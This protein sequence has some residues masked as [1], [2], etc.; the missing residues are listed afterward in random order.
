MLERIR[1]CGLFW[2]LSAAVAAGVDADFQKIVAFGDPAPGFVEPGVTFGALPFQA[3][4][5]SGGHVV[6]NALAR[7][8]PGPIDPGA[9]QGV[10]RWF[11]GGMSLV[12]REGSSPGGGGNPVNSMFLSGVDGFGRMAVAGTV[13]NGG[14]IGGLETRNWFGTPGA[15]VF[16]NDPTALRVGSG[17]VHN[18]A[19]NDGGKVAMTLDRVVRVEGNVTGKSII[20]GSVDTGGAN[21]VELVRRT[22]AAGDTGAFFGTLVNQARIWVADDGVVFYTSQLETAGFSNHTSHSLWAQRDRFLDLDLLASSAQAAPGVPGAPGWVGFVDWRVTVDRR[23]VFLGRVIVPATGRLREGLWFTKAGDGSQ[24]VVLEGTTA[25]PGD[26]AGGVIS[27][28]EE[29]DIGRNGDVMFRASLEDGRSGLFLWASGSLETLLLAGD[30]VPLRPGRRIE[31]LERAVMNPRGDLLATMRTEAA[32]GPANRTRSMWLIPSGGGAREILR[33]LDEIEI[34]PGE[35]MGLLGFDLL[36]FDLNPDTYN[37]AGQ[38]LLTVRGRVNGGSTVDALVFGAL[39]LVSAL[40]QRVPAVALGSGDFM[41]SIKTE[42]GA[43]YE[44]QRRVGGGTWTVVETGLSGD[45]RTI[46]VVDEG[47]ADVHPEAI[48]RVVEQ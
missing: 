48:Y 7:Q 24:L 23:A 8:T 35:V 16:F 15:V 43:S 22:D 21:A 32:E 19:M 1:V 29:F 27:S 37:D 41:L 28:I 13:V 14:V 17:S 47:V 3:L 4:L 20:A 39:D 30:D 33:I 31:R 6:M 5:G 2:L 12:M 11:E 9:D 46:T 45:G 42:A 40:P 34:A 44:L 10:W 18:Y 26:P 36:F 25:A 38:F